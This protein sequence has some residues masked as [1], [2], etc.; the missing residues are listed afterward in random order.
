MYL[1]F[2]ILVSALFSPQQLYSDVEPLLSTS[3]GQEGVWQEHTP[4]GE[5][6]TTL[7]G[8]T[9]V[10]A[11]Q[12]L[13]YYQYG[14]HALNAVSYLINNP[15]VYSSDITD[16][17]LSLDLSEYRYNWSKF[18]LSDRD[19]PKKL[20]HTS[21]FIYHVAV[22]LRT[23]FGESSGSSATGKQIE[24]AFRYD[25]GYNAKRR[26]HMSIIAKDAFLYSD[27]EWA[28]LVRHELDAGRPVLYMAQAIGT[29]LGHA[30]VIDGYDNDGLFHINWG[31][32]GEQNGYYNINELRDNS[33][34]SWV[35]GPMIFKGLEPKE[36]LGLTIKQ[37]Q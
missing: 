16:S 3:W 32:G 19:T 6:G 35:K 17:M 5:E 24:N 25:W 12:I 27:E 28:E 10:A 11:A 22:T 31:W 34:R 14:N 21:R 30:F 15:E 1:Y 8:C 29:Q 13:Y 23:Q 2:F 37:I 18:A 36:G 33:G 26:R 9:S 4:M 7:P 20:S